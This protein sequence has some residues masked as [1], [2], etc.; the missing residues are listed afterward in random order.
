M[1]FRGGTGRVTQTNIV[2]QLLYS[3]LFIISVII[4][5]PRKEDLFALIR[6]E[7]F[8]FL[9][10]GFS[11]LS[12]VWS[13]FGFLSFKRI[14]QIIAI[15]LAS[16]SFL[17]YVDSAEEIIKPFKYI[18]YP[19]L[20]L[21]LI[22]VIVLPEAKDP[23]FQT[24]R[25]FT[26]QKNSL[27]QIGDIS[28]IL[29]YIFYKKENSLKGKT[30]A[31]VMLLLSIVI[32]IGSGSSTSIIVL[33]FLGGLVSLLSLDVFFKPIGIRRTI[34]FIT[35]TFFVFFFIGIMIFSPELGTLIPNLF[36]K[37]TT[38]SGRTGLWEYLLTEVQFNHILGTGYNAFWVPESQR[39][40]DIYKTFYW[41][42]KQAHNGYIDIFLQSGYIG[43]VII[44]MIFINYFSKY[45]K[46]SKPHPWVLLILVLI[47]S[48]FQ[49]STLLRTG[50]TLN[51]M[52]I[53]SYL[54]VFINFYKDFL[55]SSESKNQ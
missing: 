1:P 42:P 12:I 11:V 6:R 8:L 52:F 55:W 25:G 19:Y 49:E 23:Q 16:I 54:L 33:L 18:L 34:S 13:D 10:I 51:F 17:L 37:D 20:V 36:G 35:V 30:L 24:W 28:V 15:Y 26:S 41:P 40:L 45:V 39:I 5:L 48:N 47:I 14:F 2:N 22:V 43:L 27:G 32:V 31:V 38:F 4:L 46:I 3:G 7:R 21:T 9:F 50:Q 53:F 44:V 29:C